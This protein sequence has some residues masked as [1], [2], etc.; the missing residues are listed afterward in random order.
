MVHDDND[1]DG[2][3]LFMNL[4]FNLTNEVRDSFRGSILNISSEPMMHT[5]PISKRLSICR[6]EDIWHEPKKHTC[7][8]DW[9]GARTSSISP[10]V[11]AREGE[12]EGW[13]NGGRE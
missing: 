2:G 12:S 5:L 1:D 6:I 8:L 7:L 4:H 13:T 3:Y 11:E 10:R 9:A